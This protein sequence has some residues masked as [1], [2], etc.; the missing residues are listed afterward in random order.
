MNVPFQP[1]SMKQ[2]ICL[3]SSMIW[4]C[5]AWSKCAS[6]EPPS[7]LMGMQVTIFPGHLRLM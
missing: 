5:S 6:P 3:L 2:S 4:S 1:W 7:Q